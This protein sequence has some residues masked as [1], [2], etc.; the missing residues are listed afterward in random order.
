MKP[1]TP[2]VAA[3]ILSLATVWFARAATPPPLRVG[4]AGHAFDH[5]GNIGEQAATAAASGSTIIYATGLGGDGYSGLPNPTTLSNHCAAA[6]DYVTQ[7]RAAGIQLAIG[8]VCATSIVKLDTFDAH[9][10]AALRSRFS[11]PPSAWRQQD[12]SGRPLKS[13]YGGDYEPA[14]MNHPDWR[15]YQR[16]IVHLQLE[17]GHDGIFFDNPT[18]HPDGCYC[19]HCMEAFG[20]QL[21]ADGVKIG[22]PGIESLRQL[23]VER[24]TDFLR[25]RA[26]IAR[27]FL[28]DMRRFARTVKRGALITCNN[29][30][31]AP[32][33]LY[34]QSR[35]MGYNIHELSKVEDFVVVEDMSS[36]PRVTPDGKVFEYG[37]NYRQLHA[38]S[39]GKPIVAVTIA[40][41]EYHTP[42]RLMRLAMAEAAAHEASYLAWPTWP[43]EQRTRMAADVAPQAAF[44]RQHSALLN[45][46]Q[47][48]RDAVLFLPFRRWLE[49][50]VCAATRIAQVLT[51]SNIQYAVVS[52][53]EFPGRSLATHRGILPVLI[54]EGRDVF[55]PAERARV[56]TFERNRGRFLEAS[57]RG[58][59]SQLPQILREPSLVIDGPP[60]LRGVVRDQ[61]SRTLVHLYNLNLERLGDFTDRLTSAEDVRIE[62]RPNTRRV[63]TVRAL[64]A[65]TGAT[66]GELPFRR[67]PND[68]TG[69]IEIRIPRI[70]IATLLVIE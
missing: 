62:V 70:E 25:F 21:K 63:R 46:S 22:N 57:T 50:N 19:P 31:N 55:T 66:Q 56:A 35:S 53:D 52:E 39:H 18:V 5:L 41:A 4:T 30:L 10:P 37:A 29:S 20:R 3:L 65:D 48:R 1:L 64:S 69:R 33:V 34:S 54:A 61:G 60:T 16:H 26:T 51:R 8:Y 49:T 14:C 42:A 68:T 28:A 13:W 2:C 32:D 44:L 27:E 15:A 23:A 67:I 17:S 45:D 11:T 47:P 59:E 36:Q 12:R 7:A 38:I 6:S 43:A 40:Q 9:W 58:W 24:R